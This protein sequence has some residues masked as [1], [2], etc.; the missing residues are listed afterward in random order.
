MLLSAPV[1]VTHSQGNRARG[2]QRRAISPSSR[3]PAGREIA[4]VIETE[5]AHQYIIKVI[6][7]REHLKDPKPRHSLLLLRWSVSSGRARSRRHGAAAP[8]S[9]RSNL[10]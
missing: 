8:A 1:R 9:P 6:N 4:S 5:A 2:G 10:D 7:P 3:Q